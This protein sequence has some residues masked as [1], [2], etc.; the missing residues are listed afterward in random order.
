[1]KIR[2]HTKTARPFRRAGIEFGREPT[3]LDIDEL[4]DEQALALQAEP[5]LVI[6]RGEEES[7][8]SGDQG[9]QA[10]STAAAKPAK[11]QAKATKS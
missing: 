3:I 1:M 6:E 8:G 9:K 4:S 10:E 5:M 2:V 7:K 11:R